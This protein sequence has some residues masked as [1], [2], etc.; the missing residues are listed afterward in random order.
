MPEFSPDS[1]GTVSIDDSVIDSALVSVLIDNSNFDRVDPTISSG[2]YVDHDVFWRA[3]LDLGVAPAL[4][5][6]GR[7]PE[8]SESFRDELLEL[9]RRFSIGVDFSKAGRQARE[10]VGN[11]SGIG[12]LYSSLTGVLDLWRR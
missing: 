4:D 12:R 10:L 2:L 3:D 6:I 5:P 9:R 8:S 7:A 11:W 1:P